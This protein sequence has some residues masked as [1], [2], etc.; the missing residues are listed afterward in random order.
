[1]T[2][3][4][5]VSCC[6]AV[7]ALSLAICAC[8]AT[9][10]DPASEA[11]Q[12]APPAQSEAAPPASDPAQAQKQLLTPPGQPA[13][14]P[15]QPAASARAAGN[16][17]AGAALSSA[18]AAA[19]APRTVTLPAG[20][21][22]SVR[23][24]ST[25]STKTAQAGETF[26][27]A[28]T[29]PLVD[30]NWVIA[31]KGATVEGTV[32]ESDPGGKV[33]GTASIAVA[34]TSV[35]LSDGRKLAVSTRAYGREAPSSKKK[36][37]VKVGVASGIGAAVGAIAGGGRGAAIGAGAGAGAGTGAVLLTRGDPAVIPSESV[38]TFQLK[39]PVSVTK[40]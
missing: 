21:R 29:Q 11:K 12:Q 8:S 36:D 33:K 39:E 22:L 34:I 37:A 2:K 31:E 9:K 20:T 13:G 16:Q 19:P 27:G 38:I 26:V 32:V 15:A 17:P 35:T 24:T 6:P 5:K 18:P 23:T 1:M 10:T 3:M 30:G 4:L 40:R 7:A 28:L 25:L 14:A